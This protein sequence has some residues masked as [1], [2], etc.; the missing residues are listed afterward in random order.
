MPSPPVGR[1]LYLQ[2]RRGKRIIEVN[3][4]EGLRKREEKRD[5]ML[6][7]VRVRAIIRI[8]VRAYRIVSYRIVSYRIVSHS[9][10]ECQLKQV[11]GLSTAY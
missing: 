5:F 4:E 7:G 6:V 3:E 8:R 10:A 2:W 1:V 9:I 11:S